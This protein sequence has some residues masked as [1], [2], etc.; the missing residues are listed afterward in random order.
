MVDLHISESEIVVV[1]ANSHDG[2]AE[3]L[4]QRKDI[5]LHQMFYK[6]TWSHNNLLG[7]SLASGDWICV[8]NPDIYFNES[9]Q[10]LIG[11]LETFQHNPYPI[12]APQLIYPPG[13]KYVE[14]WPINLLDFA[15]MAFSFL[16]TFFLFDQK[17]TNGRIGQGRLRSISPS[18]RMMNG[19]SVW[20]VP[21]PMGSLFVIHRKTI[22]ELGGRLW[23]QGFTF[24]AA[25]SDM[26]RAASEAGIESVVLPGARIIHEQGH[27]IRKRPRPETHYELAYGFVLYARYW[28][29]H[30][31]IFS[32]LYCIDSIFPIFF[33]PFLRSRRRKI[34][35]FGMT[36]RRFFKEYAQMAG[37]KLSGMI[38]AWSVKL[39]K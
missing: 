6:D 10:S 20:P 37:A 28:N 1:D 34:G 5:R 3:F 24:G 36:P 26:F 19:Y 32:L 8:M 22:D 33:I 38:N 7:I 16:S 23:H 21:H 30:P 13:G 39:D 31:R 2:T 15:G 18:R 4:A 17:I 12:I 9:F 14:Q 25:D 29:E 27:S 11:F 35:E